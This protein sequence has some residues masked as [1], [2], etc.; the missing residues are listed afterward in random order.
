VLAPQ[1]PDKVLMNGTGIEHLDDTVIPVLEA[2]AP[3][4]GIA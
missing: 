2:A 3:G 4:C 1:A